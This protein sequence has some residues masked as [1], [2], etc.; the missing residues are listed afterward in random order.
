[1]SS[2]GIWHHRLGSAL[3]EAVGVVLWSGRASSLASVAVPQIAVALDGLESRM[4]RCARICR[5][6]ARRAVTEQ[7]KRSDLT[8]AR[9]F[10]S[11]DKLNDARQIIRSAGCGTVPDL[12]VGWTRGSARFQTG[13]DAA[14]L[15]LSPAGRFCCLKFGH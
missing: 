14:S 13:F 5:G 12:R 10:V 1:M 7:V 9:A 2:A 15:F 3:R 8:F 6:V 4:D 11:R